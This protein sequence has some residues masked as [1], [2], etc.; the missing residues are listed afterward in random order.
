MAGCQVEGDGGGD[1]RPLVVPAERRQARGLLP[2]AARALVA[3]LMAELSEAVAA[4]LVLS[5]RAG[6]FVAAEPAA[7]PAA[8]LT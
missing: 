7:V 4:A 6:R 5:V 1:E 3:A 8:V 2:L